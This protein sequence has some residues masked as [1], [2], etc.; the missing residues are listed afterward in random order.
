VGPF[1]G[2]V[3]DAAAIIAFGAV[4]APHRPWWAVSGPL[5]A[6]LSGQETPEDSPRYDKRAERRA[7]RQARTDGRA[8]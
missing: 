8:E 3:D 7:Y 2:M 4:P 1:S 6:A 5:S